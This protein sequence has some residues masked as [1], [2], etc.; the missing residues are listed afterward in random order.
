MLVR[1]TASYSMV[2][3]QISL[4][5]QSVEPLVTNEGM[6]GVMKEGCTELLRR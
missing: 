5:A 2:T 3:M 4:N 1:M 6:T